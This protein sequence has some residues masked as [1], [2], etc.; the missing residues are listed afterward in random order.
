M[1]LSNS[2]G[3]LSPCS[4]SEIHATSGKDIAAVSTEA[5]TSTVVGKDT[6]WSKAFHSLSP[7]AVHFTLASI[8]LVKISHVALP[9]CK[10]T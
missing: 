10:E 9:I 3:Q 6:A 2:S 8:A 7:K 1:S 5:S 4:G